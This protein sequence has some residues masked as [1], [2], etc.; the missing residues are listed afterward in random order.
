M[1]NRKKVEKHTTV[2]MNFSCFVLLKDI[3][4]N[5]KIERKENDNENVQFQNTIDSNDKT[6]KDV[7]IKEEKEQEEDT[8]SFDGDYTDAQSDIVK[9]EERF[10][11]EPIYSEETSNENAG[12]VSSISKNQQVVSIT[13]TLYSENKK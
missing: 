9:E 7:N 10:G 3:F 13:N 5:I 2:G 11:S 8:C 1:S 4:K 6:I 12:E